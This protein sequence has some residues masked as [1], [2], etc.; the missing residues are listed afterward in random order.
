[1][2]MFCLQALPAVE[3]SSKASQWHVT[4]MAPDIAML[5]LIAFYV[6]MVF[7]D[8]IMAWSIE[9]K[10]QSISA[11]NEK[12][13]AVDSAAVA[14]LTRVTR[15]RSRTS[16]VSIIFEL[17]LCGVMLGAVATWYIYTTS[18]VQDGVFST[19][20]GLWATCMP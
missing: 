13:I 10:S 11:G 19:R 9:R 6:G 5:V 1:M 20:Y 7:Y 2:P 3:Y 12:L 18:L 17:C 16:L 14:P 4:Q 8:T 15:F